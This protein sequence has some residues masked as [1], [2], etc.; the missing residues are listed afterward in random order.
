MGCYEKGYGAHSD[1]T[2]QGAQHSMRKQQPELGSDSA[3]DKAVV[4]AIERAPKPQWKALGGADRDQWNERLSNLVTGALPVRQHNP[5]A[6]SQ[7][8]SAVAAGVVDMN[9]AD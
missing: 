2:K 4:I 1:A 3:K 5:E 7:A 8:A 6:L 9:P